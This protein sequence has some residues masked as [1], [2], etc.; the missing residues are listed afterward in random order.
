MAHVPRG[1]QT[2]KWQKQN[3]FE[4]K[5][6]NNLAES[7]WMESYWNVWLDRTIVSW[8]LLSGCYPLISSV[9][10]GDKNKLWR[11]ISHQEE[12]VRIIKVSLPSRI[13]KTFAIIQAT[14]P[15]YIGADVDILKIWCWG[16]IILMLRYHKFDV[17]QL[18][19]LCWGIKCLMLR[20]DMTDV[21][22]Q[23]L[24]WGITRVMLR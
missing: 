17:E 8:T 6:W 7:H 16:V 24:C 14:D 18:Q 3:I 11:D 23:V 21:V 13:V 22:F 19:I 20:Y 5:Q 9:R 4:Q 15:C 1:N 12:F 10:K 2:Q